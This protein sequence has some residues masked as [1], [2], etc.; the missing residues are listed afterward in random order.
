MLSQQPRASTIAL[1]LYINQEEH[2]HAKKT[3][4]KQDQAAKN[5]AH[6]QTIPQHFEEEALKKK[7]AAAEKRASEVAQRAADR[8]AAADALAAKKSAEKALA[9][10]KTS[11]NKVKAKF[12]PLIAEAESALAL[13]CS[14]TS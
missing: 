4:H 7:K 1:G 12:T 14:E 11:C 6:K 3:S 9:A 2:V 10:V 13:I 8:K 5:S